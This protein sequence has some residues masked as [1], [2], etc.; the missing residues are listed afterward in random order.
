M[1]IIFNNGILILV[2]GDDNNWYSAKRWQGEKLLDVLG[3]GTMKS[4]GAPSPREETEP[5]KKNGYTYRFIILNDWGPCY[6][7]NMDTGKQRE[8]K[9]IELQPSKTHKP[10]SDEKRKPCTITIRK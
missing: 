2:E 9:Y 3:L 7:E 4:M 8:I 1:S 6:L 10:F 5:F